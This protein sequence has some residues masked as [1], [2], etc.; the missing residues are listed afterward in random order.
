MYGS[1]HINLKIQ[2]VGYLIQFLALFSLHGPND[3]V[4]GQKTRS[5]R[6]LLVS[7]LQYIMLK[8]NTLHVA[9]KLASTIFGFNNPLI[10]LVM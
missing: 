6:L 10:Y 4:R 8:L 7:Y 5:N 2:Y 9:G 3:C 1:D